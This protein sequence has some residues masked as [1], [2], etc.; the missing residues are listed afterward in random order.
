MKVELSVL[1]ILLGKLN[2][3]KFFENA[4]QE[5]LKLISN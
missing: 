1:G 5:I 4:P 2:V 3:C